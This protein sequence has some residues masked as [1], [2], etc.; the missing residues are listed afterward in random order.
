MEVLLIMV[1][2]L[3]GEDPKMAQVPAE[4]LKQC[5]TY[6]QQF[7]ESETAKQAKAASAGCV[8]RRTDTPA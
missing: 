4:S 8:M 5:F 7:M 3:N 1:L 2:Y 6:A